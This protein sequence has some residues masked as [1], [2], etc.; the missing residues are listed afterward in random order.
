MTELKFGIFDHLDRARLN[1][2]ELYKQRLELIS[3]VERRGFYCYHLAEHHSTPLGMAPSPNLFLTAIAQRTSTLRFGPLVYLLPMYHPIRL[4]EEIAMLDQLSGGRL[5]V[6][7]GRGRSPIE[8]AL[9][10]SD[11]AKGQSIFSEALEILKQGFSRDEI[12]FTGEHFTFRKV[13]VELAPLQKPHPPLWYGVGSASGA[14]HLGRSGFNA[15][16]LAKPNTAKDI[17]RN[18]FEGARQSGETQSLFG[19]CRFVVVGETDAQARALAARAYPMWHQSFFELFRRFDQRPV[20]TWSSDFEVM[21]AD[22]LAVAGSPDTVAA[23]LGAQLEDTGANYVTA[24]MIFGDM[25]V[26]EASDSIDL[27]ATGVMPQLS[28]R[29]SEMRLHEHA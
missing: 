13:P 15:V 18:F 5:Q 10:A 8:L 29:W 19:L 17:C 27:F 1:I 6:G 12:D 22:G 11:I 20:Q 23:Y 4:S 24:Q 2:A 14:E 3:H 28:R 9:Y 25:T 7:V 16:T 21:S 26:A